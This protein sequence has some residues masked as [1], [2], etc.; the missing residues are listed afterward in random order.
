[1]NPLFSEFKT[2]PKDTSFFG[3]WDECSIDGIRVAFTKG[4]ILAGPFNPDIEQLTVVYLVRLNGRTFKDGHRAR[5]KKWLPPRAAEL[6]SKFYFGGGDDETG[7]LQMETIWSP[8]LSVSEA[9]RGVSFFKGRDG[10]EFHYD[11]KKADAEMVKAD[12]E[13]LIGMLKTYQT[14]KKTQTFCCVCKV[15][16]PKESLILF[17]PSGK[18]MCNPCCSKRTLIYLILILLGAGLAYAAWLF[19]IRR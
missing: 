11:F 4:R 5:L 15:H 18:R 16:F 9:V 13:H 6:D 2:S 14:L 19:L 7:A 8:L 12:V 17:Y 1:M 10:V 3:P